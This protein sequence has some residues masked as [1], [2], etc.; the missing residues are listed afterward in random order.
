MTLAVCARTLPDGAIVRDWQVEGVLGMSEDAVLYAARHLQTGE[1]AFLQEYFPASLAMRQADGAVIPRSGA[2]EDFAAGRETFLMQGAALAGLW[3]S[4]ATDH[5]PRVQ[6]VFARGAAAYMVMERYD[7]V[8]LSSELASGA[9]FPEESL[10]ALFRP[11]AMA[12]HQLHT[13]GICHLRIHPGAIVRQEHGLLLTGFAGGFASGKWNDE[14]NSAYSPIE[15][16][17]PVAPPG[18]WSDIYALA[19]VLYHCMTGAPPPEAVSRLGDVD[20]PPDCAGDYSPAFREAVIAALSCVPSERPQTIRAWCAAW[21]DHGEP[22][23]QAPR[24]GRMLVAP[25]VLPPATGLLADGPEPA[26]LSFPS[27]PRR[28]LARLSGPMILPCLGG[29]VM[30]GGILLALSQARTF[31]PDKAEATGVAMPP[32]RILQTE[33]NADGQ[34]LSAP[35]LLLDHELAMAHDTQKHIDAQVREAEALEWPEQQQEALRRISEKVA[36]AIAE[37]QALY[38]APDVA[39]RRAVA[40]SFLSVLEQQGN[41]VRASLREA[42]ETSVAGYV[43]TAERLRVNADANYRAL[44]KILAKDGR[45]EST[46]LKSTATTAYDLLAGASERLKAAANAEAPTNPIAASR[47]L[48]AISAAF[49]EVQSQAATIRE[50]LRSG[51]AHAAERN[52]AISDQARER[53]DFRAALAAAR[54]TAA[55]VERAASG[56]ESEG[57]VLTGERRVEALQKVREA[58]RRLAGLERIVLET[59]DLRGP[60]LQAALL[61]VTETEK[62]LRSLL[63]GTDRPAVAS[64]RNAPAPEVLRLLSRADSRLARDY[65]RY[66]ELQDL[67]AAHGGIIRIKGDDQVGGETVNRLYRD[68]QKL[69]AIRERLSTASSEADAKRIYKQFAEQHQ[70]IDNQL[71]RL[72]AIAARAQ[73]RTGQSAMR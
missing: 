4:R 55:A 13:A 53:R 39:Q 50:A 70:L 19:A 9:R 27:R 58:N 67:L 40:P 35:L 18:P 14:A 10:I 1:G 31:L 54:R 6:T 25:G 51:Q 16:L 36:R 23:L 30:A 62:G 45:S 42:W 15:L 8:P 41:A 32:G 52:D 47:Q 7:G 11:M 17:V 59:P 68:M 64:H 65:R 71:D 26:G 61:E 66:A 44:T 20:F 72:L 60:Q 57:V 5:L 63:E 73:R 48:A 3:A 34:A 24:P 46:L 2:A 21:P 38:A 33:S 29:V 43:E 22:L 12:L 28:L 56:R 37:M 69:A 49:G